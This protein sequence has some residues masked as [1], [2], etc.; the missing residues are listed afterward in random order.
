MGWE[1][2]LEE[3]HQKAQT[4]RHQISGSC[5][6]DGQQG[7]RSDRYCGVYLTAAEKVNLKNSHHKD[8]FFPF[9][10]FLVSV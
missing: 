1:G 10:F 8:I 9:F 2:A 3:G 6:C 4:Y 7:G 5:L